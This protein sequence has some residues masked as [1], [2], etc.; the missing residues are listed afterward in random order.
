MRSLP[1][2]GTSL[3]WMAL[4]VAGSV[5]AQKLEKPGQ[6]ASRASVDVD[7][8]Q[9]TTASPMK[10]DDR[11]LVMSAALG[12]PGSQSKP[13]CSHLVHQIYSRAGFPYPYS[14][15]SELY[16]GINEFQR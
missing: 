3:L 9:G 5:D 11:L 16:S 12:G 4:L 1:K 7:Q 13:D 14:S 10:S 6:L 15:S 2:A 8:P